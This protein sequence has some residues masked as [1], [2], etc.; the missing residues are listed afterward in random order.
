[1]VLCLKSAEALVHMLYGDRRDDY[2]WFPESFMISESRLR[3]TMFEG[4]KG[5][6]APPEIDGAEFKQEMNTATHCG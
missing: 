6:K 4:R 5:M 1:M 3:N 2:I